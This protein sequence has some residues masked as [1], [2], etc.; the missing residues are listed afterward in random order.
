MVTV[1]E[2]VPFWLSRDGKH[3]KTF[4]ILLFQPNLREQKTGKSVDTFPSFVGD[5]NNKIWPKVT[6]L[7]DVF[8]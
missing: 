6:T 8:G 5:V 4:A 3:T 2:D 1:E 7:F